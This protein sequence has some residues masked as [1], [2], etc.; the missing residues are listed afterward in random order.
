MHKGLVAG[1]AALA[2]VLAVEGGFRLLE[3]PLA[4]DRARLAG[5]REFL[6]HGSPLYRP[7]PYVN[8]VAGPPTQNAQNHPRNWAFALATHEDAPRV[9]C[10]GG[11]T[12]WGWYPH[13]LEGFLQHGLGRPVEVMNWGVPGWTSLETM[14]NYFANVQD[15]EPD[16]VVLLHAINDT[17]PRFARGYRTDLAHWRTSWTEPRLGPITRGLL[18]VSDL[19]AHLYLGRLDVQALDTFTVRQG[20]GPSVPDALTDGSQR[21]FERNIRT[22]AEHVRL[23]R[24]AVVLVTQPYNRASLAGKPVG[25][26]IDQHNQY[27]RDLAASEDY[28]LVDA[29]REFA[30]QQ[31]AGQ[32]MFLDHVHLN[33]EWQRR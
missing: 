33:A 5:L 4:V 13:Y 31:A 27:L 9:A 15:Y 7:Y 8:F 20:L 1:L 6:A 12:T 17:V 2:A 28:L 26:M 30:L 24:G 21:G 23:R 11:S 16:V 10:L 3:G 22:V 14:V 18:R 29:E 25:A 32:D 19:F